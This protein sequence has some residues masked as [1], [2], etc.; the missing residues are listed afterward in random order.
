MEYKPY[1]EDEAE[2][3][4]LETWEEQLLSWEA[5]LKM[6]EPVR[7]RDGLEYYVIGPDDR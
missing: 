5:T 2:S 7:S 4:E 6:K 3:E 1:R